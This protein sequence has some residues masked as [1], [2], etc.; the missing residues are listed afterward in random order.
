M[1][2]LLLSGALVGCYDVSG[3]GVGCVT[4]S[5]DGVQYGVGGDGSGVGVGDCRWGE[6]F[7]GGGAGGDSQVTEEGESI[8]SSTLAPS[9]LPPF[10]FT[11]LLLR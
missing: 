7:R 1:F 3:V 6:R 11:R 10:Y 9:P 2:V 4:G 8:T 5:V